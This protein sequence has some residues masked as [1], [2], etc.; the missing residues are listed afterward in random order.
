MLCCAISQVL[1][2][3]ARLRADFPG[4]DIVAGGFDGFVADVLAAAPR[5]DLPVVTGEIGDT[6]WAG[7]GCRGSTGS[8][9]AAST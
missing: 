3:Y 5:L 6:W 7:R 1:D 9:R 8:R 4:A 2:I